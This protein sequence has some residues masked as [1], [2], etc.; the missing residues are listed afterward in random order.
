MQT[1]ENR[2][3]IMELVAEL[4]SLAIEKE[5]GSK[6]A[7]V[8]VNIEDIEYINEAISPV[9]Y[10]DKVAFLKKI[11]TKIPLLKIGSE[12]KEELSIKDY[13]QYS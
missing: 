8:R 12:N 1:I 6:E 4:N 2:L 10:T 3:K 5:D 13:I 11:R 7:L 9:E